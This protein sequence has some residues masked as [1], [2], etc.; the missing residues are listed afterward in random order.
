M[1]IYDGIDPDILEERLTAAQDA[2]HA[3]ATGQQ[4]VSIRNGDTA[5]SFTA[6]DP[7]A[8]GRLATY[9]RDLQRALGLTAS[10]V[11]GVYLAG[12]KGL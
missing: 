6:S 2:Y 10:R 11:Y 12:G 5:L 3:L 4:V 8:L 7:N 1:S 9:I